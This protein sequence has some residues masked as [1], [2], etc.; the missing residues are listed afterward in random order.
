MAPRSSSPPPP[1]LRWEPPR[2]SACVQGQAAPPD[3]PV[4]SVSDAPA[5]GEPGLLA[6]P[7]VLSQPAPTPVTVDYTTLAGTATEGIDYTLTSGQVTFPANDATPIVVDVPVLDDAQIEIDETVDLQISNVVGADL[8][9]DLATGVITGECDIVGTAGN[10]TLT[11]TA[12]A[13]TICGLGGNDTISGGD[14]DDTLLGGDGDDTLLGEG[15]DDTLDGGAGDDTASYTT[16][17]GGVTVDLAAGTAT[18]QGSD[19]LSSIENAIG[20]P[21]AD[22][23]I[24]DDGPNRLEGGD[25]SDIV[26]G[27]GG[28]DTLLGGDNPDYLRPGP[29]DDSV[30]GG[31]CAVTGSTSAPR[32][33]PLDVDLEA[34]TA[35]GE[36]TD[37][38]VSIEAVCGSP[39]DDTLRGTDAPFEQRHPLRPRRPGSARG[40]RRLR[41]ASGR[42]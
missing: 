3:P 31:P 8:G 40:A 2:F 1:P 27:E 15:D 11:G 36:G 29:G 23:L 18:G 24:G 41:P 6:F 13:D 14:G 4:V 42:Q 32:R 5:T 9:T 21:Q 33:G 30:D 20:S 37:T 19:T 7:I 25:R 26:Q 16:G 12:G 22:T 39:F 34:G 17:A 35:T 38:L 28:D 10:D